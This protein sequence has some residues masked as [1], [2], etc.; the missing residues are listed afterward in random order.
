MKTEAD[1]YNIMLY[2]IN[3]KKDYWVV[4]EIN[5]CNNESSNL[6]KDVTGIKLV[7]NNIEI[8]SYRDMFDII[9]PTAANL[10]YLDK[11]VGERLVILK[12]TLSLKKIL[13]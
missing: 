3:I 11:K 7:G 13:K 8:Y 2:F 4:D 5:L 12:R 10:S 6:Y 9:S 1:F